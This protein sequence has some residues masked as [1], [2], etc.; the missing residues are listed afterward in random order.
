LRAYRVNTLIL[1][2]RIRRFF[3]PS[4]DKVCRKRP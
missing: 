3:F 4:I 2:G 1:E